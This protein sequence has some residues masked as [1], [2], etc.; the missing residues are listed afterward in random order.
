M[1]SFKKLEKLM[2]DIENYRA[3]ML[4]YGET[5]STRKVIHDLTEILGKVE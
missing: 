2:I 5:I 4:M 1:N 3:K